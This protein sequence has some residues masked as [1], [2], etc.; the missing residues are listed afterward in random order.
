MIGLRWPLT[1]SACPTIQ[2]VSKKL[3]SWFEANL[4]CTKLFT[5]RNE[6]D[7]DIQ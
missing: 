7:G 5:D 6:N 1:V 2:A 3:S 4:I